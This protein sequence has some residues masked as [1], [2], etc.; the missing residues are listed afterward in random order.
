MKKSYLKY[1]TLLSAFLSLPTFADNKTELSILA[2]GDIADCQNGK[3]QG[4][5][6]VS[7]IVK[8]Q[9]FDFMLHLGDMVYPDAT[10]DELNNCYGKYFN[11]YKKSVFPIAGNHE[12]NIDKGVPY[13][14]FLK[15]NIKEIQK[16]K[17]YDLVDNNGTFP[18]HYSFEK[19]GWS[20]I[21]L[22]SNLEGKE[23][24]DQLSWFEK[25]LKEKNNCSIV[26]FHHPLITAGVR[27][28]KSIVKEF[29]PLLNQYPPTIILNGHDHHFQES[30]M[31][32]GTKHFLIGTGGTKIYKIVNPLSE[33][34]ENISFE[35]GIL[36]LKLKKDSYSYSFLTKNK[37]QFEN[38]NSCN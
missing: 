5:K 7:E 38:N 29:E 25:K 28:I 24:E 17:Q 22:D 14:E 18:K 35:H 4:V 13:F 37:K 2:F 26:S 23:R 1:L 12:Y 8:K 15:D 10:V 32:N 16:Q 11:K 30:K 21:F 20:F 6:N 36:K 19:N 34:V 27:P 9:K 31:L 33:N 3:E